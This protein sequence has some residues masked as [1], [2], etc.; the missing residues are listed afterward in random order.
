MVTG[1]AYF[2]VTRKPNVPNQEPVVVA[3]VHSYDAAIVLAE[4]RNL[5][6]KT[7]K[8]PY[9]PAIHHA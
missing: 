3:I 2:A 4:K 1:K 5:R 6:D 8:Q 9:L 7:G